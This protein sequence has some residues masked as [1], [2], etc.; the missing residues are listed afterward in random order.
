[1]AVKLTK[2]ISREK[3]MKG[4][5]RILV[6]DDEPQILRVLSRSL[7]SEGYEIRVASDG[8]EALTVFSDWAPDLVI[9]DLAMPKIDGLELCERLRA[10]S[11]IPIIVLSASVEEH[12]KVEALD[13]GAD[14]YITKPF[15]MDEL[16]ARVR[17]ALRRPELG[18]SGGAKIIETGDFRVNLETRSVSLRGHQVRLTPKEY[19]LL[20]YLIR[21]PSKVHTHRVLLNVVWG[22]DYIEQPEYLRVFIGHLRKK[23]EPDQ[24]KPRYILTE[25]WVGYRLNPGA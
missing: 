3:A 12:I 4:N 6:V 21:H 11:P 18:V 9:T 23:I 22:K 13:L 5:Q 1:L 19:E 10:I 15:S 17:A 14:D 2:F 20:V 16:R 7:A 24:A 25:P 8:D